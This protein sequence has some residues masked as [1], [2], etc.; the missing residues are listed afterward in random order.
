VSIGNAR[1]VRR[2]IS[3]SL[4]TS[5]LTV[6]HRRLAR[7]SLLTVLGSRL[8]VWES[9]MIAA[10]IFGLARLPS[11]YDPV[12]LQPAGRSLGALLTF[13]VIRWDGDWY[14]AIARHGY[15]LSGGAHLPPRANF[16]PL[17]PLLVGALHLL[18]VPLVVGA[19][20]VSLVSLAVALYWL[21]QLVEMEIAAGC[22][23]AHPDA[24]RLAVIALAISPVSFF[25]SAAYAES[26]YLALSVGAFLM[27]RR[28]R[29][30]AAG[31]AAGLASAT[32]GP[33]LLLALGLV[34]LYLYGPRADR[35]PDRPGS[36]WWPRYRVR[37]DAGWLLLAPAGLLA[38]IGY[39]A[40]SGADA[41]AF[42]NTQ[43]V[44]WGHMFAAPW[45]TVWHGAQFAVRE[46]HGLLDG[47]IHATL[48]GTFPGA[49][50]DTGWANVLPF[51]AL[52]LAVPA[53][54][55]VWR[56]L[57]RAYGVFVVVSLL[58]NLISPVRFE[59]LQGLP[60]YLTVLFPLFIWLGA[61]L[62][63]HPRL[64]T[65]VFVASGIALALLSA[66][67]ATWHFVA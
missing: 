20:L 34:V 51:A 31:W 24:A 21:A 53:A 22:L 39:L 7:L 29:W 61:W 27:A 8:L 14:L 59:P 57:P 4:P 16:L 62:A 33:G 23:A 35:P 52:L 49:S 2:A 63:S 10:R 56:R 50:V 54:V 45:T 37:A 17:Y 15:A 66:E 64:R 6:E 26:L 67:F 11:G 47:R 48:F 38:Y 19:V 58:A 25:F 42:V 36:S 32:R 5:R 41:L 18:A 28:G 3:W 13:P 55:G 60:R 30:A 12:D 65:P 9:G 44:Y 40:V 43:R 1:Y 46:V